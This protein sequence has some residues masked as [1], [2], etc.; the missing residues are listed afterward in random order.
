MTEHDGKRI[1]FSVKHIFTFVSRLV[2]TEIENRAK[3]MRRDSFYELMFKEVD[4]VATPSGVN[5]EVPV[6][7]GDLY[8]LPIKVQRFIAENVSFDK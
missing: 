7:K 4:T 5:V 1:V 3:R 6:V 2:E 8:S